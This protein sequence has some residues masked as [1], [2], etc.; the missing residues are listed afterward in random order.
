[1]GGMTLRLGV[2]PVLVH[3]G[4]SAYGPPTSLLSLANR[5]LGGATFQGDVTQTVG[6]LRLRLAVEDALYHVTMS[7]FTAGTETTRTPL[8]HDVGFTAGVSLGLR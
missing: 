7:P 2:G 4:G 8:Q 5:T 1:M 6:V 3:L